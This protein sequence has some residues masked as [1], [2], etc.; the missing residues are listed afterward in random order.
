MNFLIALFFSG[1]TISACAQDISPILSKND[2]G[3]GQ[4]IETDT[5]VV[6]AQRR[7]QPVEDV[8]I[9]MIVLG[10][11]DLEKARGGTLKDIQQLVPSFS[12]EN[13]TGF[14]TLTM[15]GVGGGGRNIGFDPRAGVYLDGIYMSQAQSLLQSLFDVEQI[16]V[17]RGPQG[18]LFGRN[19][20][21]GAVNINTSPPTDEFTGYVRGNVG[22]NGVYNGYATISG[23]IS[24][25]VSG[26]ISISSENHDGFTTNLYDGQKLDDL[27][28]YTLR[29]QIL[30]K[31]S[32]RLDI[33]VSADSSY[34]KQNLIQG[35]PISAL[36]GQP[37]GSGALPP[38]TVDFNTRPFQNVN[39][40]GESVTVNFKTDN[41]FTLTSIFGYRNT[42]QDL[43]IDS[44]Y[45]QFDL[46]R[47]TFADEYLQSSEEFRITSPNS[48]SVKYLVGF[49]H[50]NEIG[51]TDR[52]A[53]VGRDAATTLVSYPLIAFPVPFTV[54]AGTFPGAVISNNGKVE[55][56][57]SAIYGSLDFDITSSTIL[58]MGA[59]FTHETKNILFDLDGSQSGNFGIGSLNGF[60]DARTDD[61]LSPTIGMT[62][63]VNKNQN[64][65]AKYSRGFKSGGWNADFLSVN[66]AKNPAFDT[67][68][69]DSYEV[70]T[71]G[72]LMDGRLRYDLAAYTSRYKNF[73]V[74]EFINLGG[75]ATSIE[76]KN[77]AEVESNGA[78][79]DFALHVSDRLDIGLN[80]GIV[81]AT[82]NSFKNCSTTTD[83]TGHQLPYAP[84][85]TSALTM[86]YGIPLPNLNGKLD[87]YGEYSYHGKSFSDPVN[88]T[89]TQR[90]SSRQNV[91]ASMVYSPYNS[92]WECSLWARNLFNSDAVV[93]RGRDFLGTF[94]V[95]RIEP[96]TVGIEAKYD[97]Y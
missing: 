29:A 86:E 84:N 16:E 6:T 82:F 39:L 78:E 15:R 20:V 27:E 11:D 3:D 46:F 36:F 18:H 53:T 21:A 23:P 49:F 66:A 71:K 91:N 72:R 77:A 64:I 83:C 69:V 10:T 40:S 65:Y 52:I 24:E 50:L 85:I 4:S 95:N 44:D 9:S 5:I 68:T 92:H 47:T 59:R 17:L 25:T 41:G 93:I 42:H 70:G 94:I 90:I 57:T 61:H 1:F 14:N 56:D 35:E 75:G 2:N 51:K 32:D 54:V 7:Q 31:P 87:F 79:A 81:E 89:T 8:P 62:Y 74:F 80:L 19:T 63:K 97:F 33:T 13:Q 38:R 22:N 48:S 30:I 67:E 76:L 43:Q 58:N 12:I 34:T 55:T 96:R 28:R 37:L 45:S 88:D 26:K 60:K 73:Q